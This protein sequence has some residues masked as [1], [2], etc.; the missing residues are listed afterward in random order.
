M[1]ISER[2]VEPPSSLV[3]STVETEYLEGIINLE[4][5]L[6]ILLNIEKILTEHEKESLM[7]MGETIKENKAPEN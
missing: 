4:D 1:S 6:I 7:K 5:K 2:S 3:A